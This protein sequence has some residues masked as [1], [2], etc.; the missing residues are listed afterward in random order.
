MN[1]AQILAGNEE[2]ETKLFRLKRVIFNMESQPMLTNKTPGEDYIKGSAVNYYRGD[3][4][5][6]EVRRWAALG[7]ERYPLNSTVVKEHGR[8][9]EKVWRA[10]DETIPAGLYVNELQKVIYY[11]EQAI[12]YACSQ[13]QAKSIQLLIRYFRTGDPNDFRNYNI[14]WIK[15]SSHVDFIMGF[16]EVYLD[17]CGK[18]GEWE[19]SIFYTDPEQTLLMERLAGLANY[20]EIKMPWKN[21]FKKKYYSSANCKSY[22]CNYGNRW[23]G[24][25]FSHRN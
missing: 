19:A 12:P 11:L 10:G 18:K 4:T 15:D 1:G 13:D 23:N 24:T 17:P 5:Y 3:L 14:H 16:I 8:I 9:F 20:F 25:N 6:E 2:F 22:Q 7:F 21:E